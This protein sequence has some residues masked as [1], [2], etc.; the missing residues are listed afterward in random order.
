MHTH[1]HNPEIKGLLGWTRRINRRERCKEER[2]IGK[3]ETVIIDGY[4][5]ST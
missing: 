4:E 2:V 5:V 3:Q 1:I